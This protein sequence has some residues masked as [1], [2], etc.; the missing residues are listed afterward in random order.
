MADTQTLKGLH[1]DHWIHKALAKSKKKP[2]AAKK[3]VDMDP[4]Q[5]KLDKAEAMEC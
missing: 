2:A 5:T 4:T 3:P 1:P